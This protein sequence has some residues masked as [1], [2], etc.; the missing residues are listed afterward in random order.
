[1]HSALSVRAF[2]HLIPRPSIRLSYP[3][4]F[5]PFERPNDVESDTLSLSFKH[6]LSQSVESDRLCLST[7]LNRSQRTPIAVHPNALHSVRHKSRAITR[8]VQSASK[9]QM[10]AETQIT[11]MVAMTHSPDTKAATLT[12]VA[13][14]PSMMSFKSKAA[15]ARHRPNRPN[16]NS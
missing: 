8:I 7:N 11:R 3:L 5:N 10:V 1:M 16:A 14:Y 2:V 12:E 6:S 13:T 15:N 4:S 9:P